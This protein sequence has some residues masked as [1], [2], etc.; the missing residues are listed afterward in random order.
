MSDDYIPK[1]IHLGGKP[2]TPLPSIKARDL[3]LRD[4]LTKCVAAGIPVQECSPH[5]LKYGSLNYYPKRGIIHRDG[6]EDPEPSR[7][8]HAFIELCLSAA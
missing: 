2:P 4:A 7:G 3:A 1:K 8:I 5:H 6:A